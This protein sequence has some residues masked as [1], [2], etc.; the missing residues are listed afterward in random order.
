MNG[1]RRAS[2]FQ[3]YIRTIL[4]RQSESYRPQVL[5]VEKKEKVNVNGFG[6]SY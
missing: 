1:E 4:M 5:T 3:K 6:H 2:V